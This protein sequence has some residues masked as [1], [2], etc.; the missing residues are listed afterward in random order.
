[1]KTWILRIVLTV[2]FALI[3]GTPIFWRGE[4]RASDTSAERIVVI[5]SHNEQIRQELEHAFA[6]WHEREYGEPVAIDWRKFGSSEILRQLRAQYTSLARAGSED[7]GAG[8]DL[9][10][11]G[12][13]YLF[14]KLKS[15]ITAV[16]TDGSPRSISITQP[17]EFDADFVREVFPDQTLA[18]R[19]LYDPDGHWWGVVLSSFGIV[20]NHDVLANLGIDEP[21]TWSDL[22]DWRYFGWV[23]L[24]DPSHSGS[25][26]V[27]YEAIVQRY[28]WDRGWGSLRRIGANT[29]YF[30][31]ESQQVPLDVSS[32]EVAI[33]MCV[34]F[35]G[36]YQAQMVGKNR[37]GYIAPAGETVVN[38]DP[39]ALLRGA[40]NAELARRFV[41]FLLLPE[42]QAV[43]SFRAGDPMGPVQYELRRLPIRYDMYEK[44]LNRMVDR[45]NSFEIASALP[46]GTPAYFD[47]I[48]TV[49]HAMI[50]DVH[51]E[52]RAAWSAINATEPGPAQDALIDRF[53]ALP[54]TLEELQT[55]AR[56]WR[57]DPEARTRDRLAWTK[58]FREQYREIASLR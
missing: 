38:A 56:A 55:S 15:G 1:M 12:G 48:P 3:V 52:L 42:G 20:Y 51:D 28:G 8:Y 27:T 22:G 21:Q 9:A 16:G 13:D 43:W 40:P 25:V 14:G 23:A 54:F 11:G 35:Y 10:F 2:A 47:V 58:F 19:P 39:I 7:N 50:I 24:A 18:N 5:T 46:P 37:V 34:D 30:T 32:G 33:G 41:R 17:I 57:E 49:M 45:V 53:D 26:R 44:Y 29:R 6:S 4:T 36:R 31:A